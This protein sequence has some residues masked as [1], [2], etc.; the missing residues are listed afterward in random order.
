MKIYERLSDKKGIADA[1]GN[2]GIV[3]HL[4]DNR[5]KALKCYQRKVE[6]CREIG[7][8]KE[9]SM[10]LGN[11]GIIHLDN[12]EFDKALD[13][14]NFYL[15]ISRDLNDAACICQ[16]LINIGNTKKK[17]HLLAESETIYTEAWNLINAHALQY[18]LPELCFETAELKYFQNKKIEAAEW[19]SRCVK[20]SEQIGN[21]EYKQKAVRLAGQLSK[22]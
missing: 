11:I 13:Q 21:S 5:V 12:S 17:L 16:A 15:Q 18:L 8:K 14:F 6:I 20:I 2:I 9:L 3:Y 19:N 22:L 4:Q 1:I 10:V 7:D